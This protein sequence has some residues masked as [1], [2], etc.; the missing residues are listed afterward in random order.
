MRRVHYWP[1]CSMVVLV[2][3]VSA[4]LLFGAQKERDLQQQPTTKWPNLWN[5]PNRYRRICLNFRK[6]NWNMYP[7][8]RE[9]PRSLHIH[10]LLEKCVN[11]FFLFFSIFNIVYICFDINITFR[12]FLVFFQTSSTTKTSSLTA[13]AKLYGKDLSEYDDVD[14]ETLLA[15]LSPEEINILAKEVD[16]DVSIE[17]IY[18]YTLHHRMGVGYRDL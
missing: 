18:F 7:K 11:L 14:V 9:E 5:L 8:W 17:L 12:F 13:P 15:Q 2:I 16:P 4:V 10:C 1:L 3:H 6:S